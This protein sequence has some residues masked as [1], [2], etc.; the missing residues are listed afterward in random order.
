[1]KSLL[2][3]LRSFFI[4]FLSSLLVSVLIVIIFNYST[5]NSN[6]QTIG[7]IIGAVVTFW[8]ILLF[9]I[10]IIYLIIGIERLIYVKIK[11]IKQPAKWKIKS[12]IIKGIILIIVAFIS[13]FAIS[14]TLS[15]YSL[16]PD[17]LQLP[18]IPSLSPLPSTSPQPSN[19]PTQRE[20]E[21]SQG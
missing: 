9:L 8:M 11:R 21:H 17:N 6:Y 1:M 5:S 3:N 10:G 18:N 14:L 13:F 4:I 7:S 16:G 15:F 20:S 2:S 12:L 19:E